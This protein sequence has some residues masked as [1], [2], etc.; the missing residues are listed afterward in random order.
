MPLLRVRRP[1]GYFDKLCDYRLFVDGEEVGRVSEG[2][3]FCVELDH[4]RHTLHAEID[5]CRSPAIA[6]DLPESG[7]SIT[8]RNAMASRYGC[9]AA[10]LVL[11]QVFLM[12]GS[13]LAIDVD[14]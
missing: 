1:K 11:P 13:Y 6:Y 8:L 4:G 10:L 12:R 3:E 5:W 2:S 14:V 7:G 9:A